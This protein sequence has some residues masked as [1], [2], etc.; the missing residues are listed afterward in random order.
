VSEKDDVLL[1]LVFSEELLGRL[2]KAKGVSELD[3]RRIYRHMRLRK[4][5]RSQLD[6][7]PDEVWVEISRELEEDGEQKQEEEDQ[8]KS[9]GAVATERLAGFG[10]PGD[11][12]A[13]AEGGGDR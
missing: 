7:V 5:W 9:T 10:V 8:S 1:L 3:R 11:G 6:Y 12:D 13:G 4:G 2:L